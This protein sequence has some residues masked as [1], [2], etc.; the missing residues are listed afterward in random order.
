MAAEAVQRP[1]AH[2]PAAQADRQRQLLRRLSAAAAEITGAAEAEGGATAGGPVAGT[3]KRLLLGL[4][5]VAMLQSRWL[6]GLAAAAVLLLVALLLLGVLVVDTGRALAGWLHLSLLDPSAAQR[7][8]G[9]P[10][11]P[12][13][14]L[15]CCFCGRLQHAQALAWK[16]H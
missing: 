7:Q 8:A 1:A 5:A 3:A 12:A 9:P 16:H 11:R 15:C 14:L 6:S 4:A 2:H 13:A 10:G